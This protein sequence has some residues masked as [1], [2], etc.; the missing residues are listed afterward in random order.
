METLKLHIEEVVGGKSHVIMLG[1][2]HEDE[3]G[4]FFSVP[5]PRHSTTKSVKV[6]MKRVRRTVFVCGEG[7]VGQLGL[8]PNEKHAAGP[9]PVYFLQ[10]NQPKFQLKSLRNRKRRTSDP[11]ASSISNTSPS[12]SAPDL[13]HSLELEVV[14]ESNSLSSIVIP[15]LSLP[16]DAKTTDDETPDFLSEDQAFEMNRQEPSIVQISSSPLCCA[17]VTGKIILA[18][19]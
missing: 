16:P 17:A 13:A 12:T 5:S 4:D 10:K 15:E 11:S 9:M 14:N 7:P 1:C 3:A 19:F 18:F 8:G 6:A 2:T